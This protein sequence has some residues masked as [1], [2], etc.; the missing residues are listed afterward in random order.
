MEKPK[1]SLPHACCVTCFWKR[2]MKPFLPAGNMQK[3]EL[4]IA[5]GWPPCLCDPKQLQLLCHQSQRSR[6]LSQGFLHLWQFQ[7]ESTFSIF[8]GPDNNANCIFIHFF[9]LCLN[10]VLLQALGTNAVSISA[11]RGRICLINVIILLQTLYVV[12]AHPG[13][14][15]AWWLKL[16]LCPCDIIKSFLRDTSFSHAR[17]C[18][19]KTDPWQP[20]IIHVLM[21]SQKKD[22][23]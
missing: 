14:P 19:R 10:C 15:S 3:M 21:E 13:H 8:C 12:R 2:I 1:E 23:G 6:Q 20:D 9:R 18:C 16:S 11:F 22:R 5:P 4:F 17:K 7:P